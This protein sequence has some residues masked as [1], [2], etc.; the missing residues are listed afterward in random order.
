MDRLTSMEVF[1][2]VAETG[3]FAAAADAL[4][5]SGAMVGKHIRM[6]EEHLGVQTSAASRRSSA[7]AISATA[8]GFRGLRAREVGRI[9]RRAQWGSHR[10]VGEEGIEDW[11]SS[12]SQGGIGHA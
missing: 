8:P 10:P 6:L 7:R 3:S 9:R 1:V 11:Q 5:I 12:R 4:G 2:K